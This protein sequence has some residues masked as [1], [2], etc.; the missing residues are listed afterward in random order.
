MLHCNKLQLA[1]K[2]SLHC[3]GHATFLGQHL[4]DKQLLS[5]SVQ[6]TWILPFA[7]FKTSIV[8]TNPYMH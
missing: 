4:K 8:L 2:W 1:A 7:S 3:W 6:Y 5:I